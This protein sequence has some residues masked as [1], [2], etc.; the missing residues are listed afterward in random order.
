[1]NVAVLE[2]WL[3]DQRYRPLKRGLRHFSATCLNKFSNQRYRPLKRGLRQVL[4]EPD[5]YLGLIR[6][7][8]RLNE[9]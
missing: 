1:M 2:D 7:T 3:V 4:L 9:D 6:D 5:F 8:V